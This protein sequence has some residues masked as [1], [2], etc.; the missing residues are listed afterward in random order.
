M[1]AVICGTQFTHREQKFMNKV[2]FEDM[3]P[4]AALLSLGFSVAVAERP[5]LF[6]SAAMVAEME[7]MRTDLVLSARER[8]LIDAVEILEVLTD[9][10]RF[11]RRS[12]RKPDGSFK[13]RDEWPEIA[14]RILEGD[15]CEEEVE[16]VR[17]HDGEDTEGRGGWESG[18][19][20]RKSKIKFTSPA[21]LLELAMKHKGVDAM[22]QQKNETHNHLHLHAEVTAKLQG[23]LAREQKLIDVTPESDEP[24]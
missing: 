17:S 19:I 21:K 13:P 6:V 22:V 1:S 8:G 18:A 14:G 5:S 16:S 3:S 12:I 7:R 20:V 10:I 15:D 11:D 4:R 9:S 2:V 24:R 23:A